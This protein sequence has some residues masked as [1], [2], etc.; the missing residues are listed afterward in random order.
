MDYPV[1]TFLDTETVGLV[2]PVMRLQV[3]GEEGP[4]EVY[5]PWTHPVSETLIRLE[6]LAEGDVVG[7]NLAFDWFHLTKLYDTLRRSDCYDRPPS[8]AEYALRETVT[9]DADCLKPR[10]AC[11]LMLHARRGPYQATMARDDVRV[12]RVPRVLAADLA[13]ELERRVEL[14]DVYFHRSTGERWKV[15][16]LDPIEPDLVNVVLRFG[17]STSLA[18]LAHDALGATKLGEPWLDD[19]D[20][21]PQDLELPYRPHSG[22]WPA[23]WGLHQR[24]WT[25][26][27]AQAYARRD[28]ELTRDLWRSFGRPEPGDDDSELACSV[29]ACR[30]RGWRLDRAPLEEARDA[31]LQEMEVAPRAPVAARAY[32]EA[33]ASDLE[34]LAI[35]DTAKATL[36]AL[37]AWPGEV[38]RRARLVAQARAA[39]KVANL[40]GKLLEAGRCHFDFK[41]LGTLSG[42]MA[43]AGG[44]NPQGIN[45]T[46]RNAFPL[47]DP[48]ERL[49]GGDFAGFEVAIAAA[50]YGDATL[51]ADLQAGRSLH[52]L[53]GAALYDQPYEAIVAT[54]GGGGEGD[55]YGKAKNS[56]FA[57]LYGAHDEK[58]AAT[59]GVP[60]ETA[61]AALARFFARY[62]GV[63]EARKRVHDAFCSMRQPGGLGTA[64]EWHEPAEHVES[65]LGFRRYYHVE[66]AICR[67]LF[68]LAQ[69]PTGALQRH[70]D[71]KV[72]RRDRVQTPGGATRSALYAA[73]FQIQA[74]AMRSAAN[75]VIQSTGAEITKALQRRIWDRQPVGVSPFVVRPLNVHDE[76]MVA[77]AP[78]VSLRDVVN[79]VLERYRATVPLLA[80]DWH[81]EMTTWA[82]K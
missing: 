82:E 71:V 42:R 48:D 80:M 26:E 18:A 81:E 12:R 58:V 20:L 21:Y 55:L 2:G 37:A 14:P 70:R 31:A 57:M 3:A 59:A 69:Q 76:V 39:E 49:D 66:N 1:I 7:F 52:A 46:L 25:T 36:H 72:R 6:T 15:E 45:R 29:G 30:W 10:R 38:G 60:P 28:V 22:R 13:A 75:H 40:C 9:H 54:K 61:S 79:E 77:R 33:P 47:A 4:V 32:L 24:L 63:Q 43:G 50:A 34:K 35:P 67:T 78:G 62:P 56:M 5:D 11:D 27:R 44:I 74:R 68:D 64:V 19:P 17:G 8:V 73:A 51:T 41:V 23:I 16:E 65:L 53:L